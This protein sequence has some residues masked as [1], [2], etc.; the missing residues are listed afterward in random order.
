MGKPEKNTKTLD[1]LK[2]GYFSKMV[3]LWKWREV[4]VVAKLGGVVFWYLFTVHGIDTPQEFNSSHLKKVKIPK[5]KQSSNQLFSQGCTLKLHGCIFCNLGSTPHPVGYTSSNGPFSIAMW[6]YRNVG[7][8]SS[9]IFVWSKNKTSEGLVKNRDPCQKGWVI[10]HSSL[11]HYW[12]V[13]FSELFP[14]SHKRTRDHTKWA[15]TSY[16]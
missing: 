5:G 15:P 8:S 6:V 10:R 13:Q 7:S 1:K 11:R 2:L 9:P 12:Y 16:K 4:K 14:S 3:M